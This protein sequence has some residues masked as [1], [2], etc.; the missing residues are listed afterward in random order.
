M[1]EKAAIEKSR[2]GIRRRHILENHRVVYAA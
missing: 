1:V 2:N